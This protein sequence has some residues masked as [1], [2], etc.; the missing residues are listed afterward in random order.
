MLDP[1]IYFELEGWLESWLPGWMAGGGFLRWHN[2]GSDG[3]GGGDGVPKQYAVG[4]SAALPGCGET[5]IDS[6]G[7][8]LADWLAGWLA[9]WL[10]GGVA[11]LPVP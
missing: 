6:G 9:L 10:A 7:D 2:G 11:G 5:G 3:C 1:S 8:W 4:V